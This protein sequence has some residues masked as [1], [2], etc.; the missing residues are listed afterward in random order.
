MALTTTILNSSA[1]SFMK[2]EICFISRSTDP[3]E[4]VLSNVVM[5]KVAIDLCHTNRKCIKNA[6]CG[7]EYQVQAP[8]LLIG[9][10]TS[11]ILAAKRFIPN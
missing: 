5:A 2:E 10:K 8:Y 7:V 1:I 3:S 11:V 6:S 9:S 4:P